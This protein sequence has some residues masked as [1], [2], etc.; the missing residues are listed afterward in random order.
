MSD[1][2]LAELPDPAPMTVPASAAAAPRSRAAIAVGCASATCAT[3]ALVGLVVASDLSVTLVAVLLHVLGTWFAARSAAASGAS[4]SETELFAALAAALPGIGACTALW[5]CVS[6]APRHASNAH[7]E[8]EALLVTSARAEADLEHELAVNSYT[9]VVRHGSLEEKRNLLRRL[10]QLGT[11]RHLSIVRQFLFEDEPELRLCAYAELA[12][13]GQT[14]EERIGELRHAAERL[15]GADWEADA[16]AALAAANRDYA[17]SGVLDDEM[18]GYWS[19]RAEEIAR[20]ALAIDDACPPA[21]RVLVLVLADR[22]ALDDAWNIICGWPEE[23]D[24]EAE[25]V[26]AEVAFRRH[27][28]GECRA[29]LQRLD[30]AGVGAPEWLR[31]AVRG[32]AST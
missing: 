2:G 1:V 13:I 28:I 18:A 22:G 10:A 12:R 29:S 20:R 3:A 16:L 26:R 7:A 19:E 14:H 32:N 4:R 21:Q 30:D 5:F 11:P 15:E 24:E 25:L 23:F 8:N 9:Q 17:I 27:A 6:R 31:T